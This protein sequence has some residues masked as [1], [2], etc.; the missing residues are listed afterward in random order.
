MGFLYGNWPNN[1]LPADVLTL[2]FDINSGASATTEIDLSALASPVG[3]SFDGSAETISLSSSADSIG[4]L[5]IDAISGEVTLS[6]NPDYETT[7]EY[8]FSVIATD[9]A[10][11]QSNPRLYPWLSI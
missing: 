2:T 6:E 9:A 10:G 1:S 4:A 7:P 5:S 11:N 8:N 3:F